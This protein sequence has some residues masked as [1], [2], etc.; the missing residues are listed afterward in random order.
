VPPIL[1]NNLKIALC[2]LFRYQGQSLINLFGLV[3][4]MTCGLLISLHQ[5]QV[6]LWQLSQGRGPD[7]QACLIGADAGP[8]AD[9][10]GSDVPV[11]AG[12]GQENVHQR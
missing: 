2:S 12:P 6:W 11:G 10:L 9:Q 7:L 3:I 4:G 1:L 5:E 8:R